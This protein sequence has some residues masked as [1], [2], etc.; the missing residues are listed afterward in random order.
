MVGKLVQSNWK[1]INEI[2]AESAKRAGRS[3]NQVRVVGVAKKQTADRVKAALEAGLE[4]IGENY[5]QEFTARKKQ[6]PSQQ[7]DWHFVGHLQSNKVN[8][9]V[10]QVELIHSVDR[11][12]LANKLGQVA[13]KRKTIQNILM[14]INIDA[15]LSKSGVLIEDALQL[16]ESIQKIQGIRLCGLMAMPSLKKSADESRICFARIRQ[17]SEKW[18]S[19]VSPGSV[20]HH[21]GEISMGT[22]S[23]FSFAVEEGATLVR[24]GTSLFGPRE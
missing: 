22:T 24:L 20:G 23:D 9:V 3:K 4:I 17:L 1:Q 6:F 16:L 19:Y 18:K 5:A 14:E 2:I 12:S 15:E 13:E 11:I 7:I 8:V 10:G 21:L